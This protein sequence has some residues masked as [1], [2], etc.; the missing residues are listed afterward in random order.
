MD[1]YDKVYKRFGDPEKAKAFLEAIG[2]DQSPLVEQKESRS[3]A[4]A[5]RA[6]EMSKEQ[7]HDLT[8]AVCIDKPQRATVR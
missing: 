5:A 1:N 6:R 2:K 7:T 4:S 8:F 3:A